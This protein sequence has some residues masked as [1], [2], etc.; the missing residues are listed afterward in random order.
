MGVLGG[1]SG[2]SVSMARTLT[3]VGLLILAAFAAAMLLRLGF[4]IEPSPAWGVTGLTAAV[5]LALMLW[6]VVTHS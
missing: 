6:G 4:G 3:G 1:A 5:G 2:I